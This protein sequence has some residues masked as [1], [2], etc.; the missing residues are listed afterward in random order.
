M[1][2]SLKMAVFWY[3]AACSLVDIDQCFRG[4]Y[5]IGGGVTLK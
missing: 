5:G 2:T 1:A 3:I 4:A